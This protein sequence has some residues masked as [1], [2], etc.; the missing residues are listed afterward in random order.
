VYGVLVA[1]S[2]P[3]TAAYNVPLEGLLH[4]SVDYQV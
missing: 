2:R 1:N 3:S 4:V